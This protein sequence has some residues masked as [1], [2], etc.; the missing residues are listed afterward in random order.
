MVAVWLHS[1]QEVLEPMQYVL[2]Y[3]AAAQN[4]PPQEVR[5]GKFKE[6][7][8]LHPSENRA[9]KN[10][11]VRFAGS[12]IGVALSQNFKDI[13]TWLSFMSGKSSRQPRRIDDL[14]ELGI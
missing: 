6:V 7:I 4:E 11:F 8:V 3:Y 12:C 1:R 10:A 14:D 5:A 2:D 9:W 13:W